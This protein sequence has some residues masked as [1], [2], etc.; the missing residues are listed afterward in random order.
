MQTR[1]LSL[2]LA[3][4]TLAGCSTI[5][6]SDTFRNR[7]FDYDRE[8]VNNLPQNLQTPAGLAT[9]SFTPVHVIPAGPDNYPAG[10][11][12]IMT[13]PGFSRQTPIPALPTDAK[14]SNS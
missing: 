11:P 9:P 13:P 10:N 3:S 5:Q 12:P 6:N 2:I 7:T 1:L 14:S 8:P 4:L